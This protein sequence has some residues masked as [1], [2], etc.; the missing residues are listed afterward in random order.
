MKSRIAFIGLVALVP[1]CC[2]MCGMCSDSTRSSNVRTSGVNAEMIV[3]S[4]EAG[5]TEV[6]VRVKV[7]GTFSNT[8]LTLA[9]GDEIVADNGS[10]H[11]AL[12]GTTG[13]IAVPSNDGTLPT[14]SS[15]RT[16]TVKFTRPHD[17]S[18]PGSSVVMP[19]GLAFGSPRVGEAFDS[20]HPHVVITWSPTSSEA[21]SWSLHGGCIDD[22][23][24]VDGADTG[25][26][27]AILV[28]ARDADGGISGPC[29]VVVHLTR[30]R[31]GKLDPAF[32]EGG[33]IMATQ[34]RERTIRF[35]P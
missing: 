27:E 16:I 32:G 28:A 15:G 21:V 6:S 11:V 31:T 12:V 1:G 20:A 25:R 3:R 8:F 29:D 26:V 17:V 2:G 9:D 7:G 35:T 4:G 19:H 30:S 14:D 10:D 24:G 18:A 13:L 33:S 5:P 23:S 34:D 22:K